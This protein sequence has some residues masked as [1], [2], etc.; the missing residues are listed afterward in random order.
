MTTSGL[1]FLAWN[2]IAVTMGS[3]VRDEA[4]HGQVF[5]DWEPGLIRN[6]SFAQATGWIGVTGE[7]RT[8]GGQTLTI[9]DP[10][11]RKT[12]HR[13]PFPV[14]LNHALDRSG[15]TTAIVLPSEHRMVADLDIVTTKN[16]DVERIVTGRLHHSSTVS[17]FPDLDRL[18]YQR[19]DGEIETVNR[20]TREIA[21][22]GPG[23][24]PSVS[25]DGQ[26]IA[27][28]RDDGIVLVDVAS[29][30]ATRVAT[31][32][33]SPSAG[34][35]WSPDGRFVTFGEVRGVTGKEVRFYLL[36]LETGRRSELPLSFATGLSLINELPADAAGQ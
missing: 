2:P 25:P 26:R 9:F 32:N 34:L 36:D 33:I 15:A 28:E 18:A 23:R 12:I 8:N 16:G 35:S 31:G 17:W 11:R 10:A 19:D 5:L 20:S 21:S 29:L 14:V 24:S 6:C 7:D 3:S 30:E 1:A 27:A 13:Y 4:T 22:I